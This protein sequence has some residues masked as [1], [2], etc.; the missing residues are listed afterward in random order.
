MEGDDGDAEVLR[1]T[2][3][4]V[5]QSKELEV[6]DLTLG[7]LDQA[8]NDGLGPLRVVEG[9]VRDVVDIMLD[10]LEVQIS[11]AVTRPKVEIVV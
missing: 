10:T 3:A 5:V 7:T 6:K 4:E 11:T 2:L 8:I 1:E 9:E